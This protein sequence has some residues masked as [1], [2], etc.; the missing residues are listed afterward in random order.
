MWGFN[1]TNGTLTI[2][3]RPSITA[4]PTNQTVAAGS[5]VTLAVTAGGAG[6]GY[7]WFFNSV[8]IAGAT[9]SS[10]TI[11]NFQSVSQGGYSVVLTNAFGPVTSA[12]AALYLNWPLR[13]VECRANNNGLFHA[14]LVGPAGTNIVIE[15][16]TDWP[17]RTPLATNHAPLGII[18]FTNAM[19]IVT[20]PYGDL[21]STNRFYRAWLAP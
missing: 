1:P 13:F 2:Y 12:P 19:L 11:T 15:D 16:C 10:L 5:N 14:R 9:T 20:D 7:Q 6:L 4:D 17:S 8:P 21:T 3:A 18:D